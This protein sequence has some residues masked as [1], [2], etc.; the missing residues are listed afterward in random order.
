MDASKDHATTITGT[1][2]MRLS[3]LLCNRTLVCKRDQL[4]YSCR[5]GR[6]TTSTNACGEWTGGWLAVAGDA[7]WLQ[8]IDRLT[9]CSHA[10][11]RAIC[12]EMIILL[13]S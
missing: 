12:M 2:S 8:S 1:T 11:Y 6:G 4:H 10:G 7:P 9:N 3:G 5:Q 13:R